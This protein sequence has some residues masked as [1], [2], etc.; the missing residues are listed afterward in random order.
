MQRS[1][2]RRLQTSHDSHSLKPRHR[3]ASSIASSFR[4][5][6]STGEN[7]FFLA[8]MERV[9]RFATRTA[10]LSHS[11]AI[12]F[13]LLLPIGKRRIKP[14]ATYSIFYLSLSLYALCP[15]LLLRE[16]LIDG[17]CSF[18]SCGNGINRPARACHHISSGEDTFP[19]C[20]SCL[21]I[22]SKGSIFSCIKPF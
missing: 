9:F 1:G 4:K 17:F 10:F 5:P 15:M 21:R 8:F 22:D 19:G 16:I 11:L 6:S 12:R 2:Q 14:A 3:R 18:F 7:P 20:C 13:F